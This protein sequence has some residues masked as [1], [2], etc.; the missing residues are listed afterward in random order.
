MTLC[1]DAGSSDHSH[2]DGSAFSISINFRSV[3]FDGRASLYTSLNAEQEEQEE[4]EE[5]EAMTS[6][7][8]SRRRCC[9]PCIEVSTNCINLRGQERVNVAKSAWAVFVFINGDG[10]SFVFFVVVFLVFLVVLFGTL[11]G[12]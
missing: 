5:E 11:P 10:S 4:E 8:R 3:E 7:T 6:T 2:N 9:S 12:T 1:E